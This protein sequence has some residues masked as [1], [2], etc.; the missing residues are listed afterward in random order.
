MG[1]A[2]RESKVPRNELFITSKFW[3]QF[4][5]PENV[6]KCLD[7]C[8]QN[9]GIDYLDLFLAH[10]PVVLKAASNLSTAKS[11][12]GATDADKGI[13]TDTNGKPI[14]D[15]AHTCQSI[16]AANDRVG[17]F[18]PTW[19][20]MQRLV[21]TG[22]VRAVG[23][24]NFNIAQLQ[25]ILSAGGEVPVSCNQ[26]EAHPRFPNTQLLDFMQEADIM[27]AVYSP[28]GGQKEGGIALR[29]NPFV[30]RLAKKNQMGVGQLLHS[31]AVQRGTI[32]IGKSQTLG[33]QHSLPIFREK[34]TQGPQ[35]A[36]QLIS[37]YESCRKRICMLST[38]WTRALMVGL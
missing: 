23:V 24:S 27:K 19:R 31:W 34:L 38:V 6:K 5:A 13:A 3:P 25:E 22:K 10:W 1:V 17:T 8:L 14:V 11:G 18:V 26:I 9:M 37:M 36:L 20:A 2:I 28:L 33:E 30:V 15:W 32:P 35:P 12:P 29:E 4:G 16:A 21:T 7:V